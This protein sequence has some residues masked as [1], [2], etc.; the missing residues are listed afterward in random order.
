MIKDI[1]YQSIKIKDINYQSI[2][3]LSCGVLSIGNPTFQFAIKPH[4]FCQLE[5]TADLTSLCL[6]KG[7]DASPAYSL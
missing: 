1:N 2:K 6:I 3:N 7:L 5:F 4:A